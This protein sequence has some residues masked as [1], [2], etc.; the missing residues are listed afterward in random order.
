MG[1]GSSIFFNV[2]YNLVIYGWILWEIGLTGTG[3]DL[4]YG[5]YIF[6]RSKMY[7]IQTAAVMNS[8]RKYLNEF[9]E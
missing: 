5:G 9:T 3:Q 2:Y 7:H 4:T 1:A 6:P 8:N